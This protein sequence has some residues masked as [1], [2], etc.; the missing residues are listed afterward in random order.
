MCLA[1][2]KPFCAS[3]LSDLSGKAQGSDT[4]A[5]WFVRLFDSAALAVALRS[6]VKYRKQAGSWTCFVLV[7]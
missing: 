2:A 6:G 5:L 7:T 1:K 3:H 4:K